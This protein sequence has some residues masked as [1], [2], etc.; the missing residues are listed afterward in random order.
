VGP[1]GR[2]RFRPRV[3]APAR[4]EAG[5][6]SVVSNPVEP[7]VRPSLDTALPRSRMVGGRLALTARLRPASAGSITVRLWH[8]GRRLAP[9]SL[10]P[11]GTLVL[12]T[13][14]V[15]DY[16][17]QLQVAGAN[18]YAGFTRT[19]RA[20]VHVPFLA[21]GS[22]G[23]SVRILERRLAELRYALRGIDGLYAY[24][25]YEAVLAFQKVNGLAR[26]GRV[27]PAVWKRLR[28]ARQPRARY[29]GAHHLEVDK[30]RQV[31]FEVRGGRVV[32][33]VHVSTGATGNTPVGRWRVYRKVVGWDWVLWYPMYFLRGFA[34]HGYPSVPAFPASH[35]CVR[36]PMWIA[37]RLF[38]G[39]PYGQT[40]YVY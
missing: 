2:F 25:T 7:R 40:V 19:L 11:G 38:A 30:R 31:L 3:G 22:R 28:R 29:G 10:G 6:G 14:R 34:V 8:S 39:N 32:R 23:P 24:D 21:L 9:R 20:T 26:T 27:G 5:F 13:R 15:G 1:S 12:P 16:V 4:Y 18:G 17:V 35:G 37:P 33:I 36:V